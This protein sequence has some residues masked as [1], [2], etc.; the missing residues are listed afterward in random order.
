[1]NSLEAS[2][3]IGIHLGDITIENGEVYGDG[4]NVA[5][6]I[7][8]VA[9]PGSIYI[10]EAVQGA[11]KGSDIHTAFRGEK[12]LKNVDYPVRVYQV[13]EGSEIDSRAMVLLKSHWP[14]LVGLV[15]L[16]GFAIWKFTDRP[17]TVYGKTIAVLPLKLHNADSASEY[18][19]QGVTEELIWSIGKVRELTVINPY[20][21]L[22]FMASVAPVQEARTEL[23][24]SDYFLS[25]TM[26]VINDLMNLDLALYDQQE[27]ELWSNTYSGDIYELPKLAGTIAVDVATFIRI[28]LS[29]SETSRIVNI[30]PVDPES[31]K[32]LL[33]GR[34]HLAKFT[35][36]DIAIGLNYLKQAIDNDPTSSRAWSNLA[37]G[38]VTMGHSPAPPPGV[39]EEAAAA[40]TRALQLDSLNAEAWAWLATTKSYYHW[41]Y[42]EAEYCYNKANA[43]NPNLPMSHYHYSWHL[44][45]FDS[46]DK[47]LDE[48]EIAFKLD[49]LDPFQAARLAHIYQIAG[50]LDSAMLEVKRAYRLDPDFPLTHNIEGMI[51][52]KRNQYDSAATAFH[53]TGPR[54]WM[55]LGMVYLKADRYDEVMKIIETLKSNLNPFNSVSLALLYAEID[56]LDQ[57]FEYANYEPTHA[58][59][60]W[61]RVEVKNPKVI[62]DPR[63]EQLMSKMNLPMPNPDLEPATSF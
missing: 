38:L 54:G 53:R 35:P 36:Q 9:E 42:R 48:H 58:F 33:L 8:S 17:T 6:R 63:F 21:T 11:I 40:A 57:F 49:P 2:L 1:M 62:N 24:Q 4:V 10:S 5:S 56:S 59:H 16:V 43:L 60:P 7:E 26:E 27:Q 13:V 20:S 22:Q 61:L 52:L 18:L 23:Q 30:E 15:L 55:G 14:W 28:N 39:K 47:A 50:K 29:E 45:L 3:R 34:H 31:F 25:G 32:L 44:Y 37:G 19:V 51:H 12:K 41:D 46:L